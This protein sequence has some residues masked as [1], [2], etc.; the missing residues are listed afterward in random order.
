MRPVLNTRKRKRGDDDDILLAQALENYEA[1]HLPLFTFQSRQVEGR[2]NWQN[3][4]ERQRRTLHVV[5]NRVPRPNEDIGQALTEA[6][7]NHIH[8]HLAT[9]PGLRPHDHNSLC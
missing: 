5:Q 9:V 2:R 4:V 8:D 3:I 7:R 6:L 1:S